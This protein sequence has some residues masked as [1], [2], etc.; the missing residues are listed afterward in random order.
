MVLRNLRRGVQK[1]DFLVEILAS[2]LIISSFSI[3]ALSV[4]AEAS[5]TSIDVT[6]PTSC[7]GLLAGSYT[8]PQSGIGQIAADGRGAAVCS[9]SLSNLSGAEHVSLSFEMNSSVPV[10]GPFGP[11]VTAF[12]GLTTSAPVRIDSD[13][14]TIFSNDTKTTTTTVDCCFLPAFLAFESDLWINPDAPLSGDRTAKICQQQFPGYA[15]DNTFHSY[16]IDVDFG[17]QT[18]MWAAD[19]GTASASCSGFAFLP[20]QM[21][22]YARSTDDGNSMIAQIRNITVSTT[23]QQPDFTIS[24]S[25]TTSL[26]V[27]SGGW[28]TSISV[29]LQSV[30]G[31]QGMVDLNYTADPAIVVYFERNSVHL[32]PGS[33]LLVRM[34]VSIV[35]EYECY[36]CGRGEWPALGK[37]PTILKA[38]GDGL[39]R[40]ASF[41]VDI[42]ATI[43]ALTNI[44]QFEK[45]GRISQTALGDCPATTSCF[46]AQQNFWIEAPNG[47]R[48][49]WA[50][51]VAIFV[52]V[53]ARCLVS[54]FSRCLVGVN[55]SGW[56]LRSMFQVWDRNITRTVLSCVSASDLVQLAVQVSSCTKQ[57]FVPKLVKMP[58]AVG[59]TSS[60]VADKLVMIND[61]SQFLPA[62]AVLTVPEGSF[63]VGYP[64]P[65]LHSFHEDPEMVISGPASLSPSGGAS[66]EFLT[67]SYGH[68]SSSELLFDSKSD[69]IPIGRV[70]SQGMTQTAEFSVNLQW[71]ETGDFRWLNPSGTAV[72]DQGL[73]LHPNYSLP[74]P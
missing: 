71:N 33:Q 3:V 1:P 41:N 58:F 66:V 63:I 45:I 22:F 17:S 14:S 65:R 37:Y 53:E 32:S 57:F 18:T 44:L 72:M 10:P 21:V 46:T 38:Q 39:S 55:F 12:L 30:N 64:V 49:Y 52:P 11:R 31:F 42:R 73:A 74:S 40:Q 27:R 56:A 54:A 15:D 50:Q 23:A 60:I 69:E 59:F 7:Q 67:E 9:W 20:N 48:I 26:V 61:A 34:N 29:L 24:V 8:N 70:L 2:I 5:T 51:N 4:K 6:A 43:R 25:P 68:L 13:L 35:P 47:T 62:T 19:G 28:N 36:F 16:T